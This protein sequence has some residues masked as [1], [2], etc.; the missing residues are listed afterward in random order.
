[1]SFAFAQRMSAGLRATLMVTFGALWLSGGGWL[2]LH[3]FFS[4][5]SDFGPAQNAWAPTVLRIH[6]WI[7]VAAVFLLGWITARH[8][9]DRWPHMIKRVSGLAVAGAAAILA[10]TGYAL[11]YTTDRV[12]EAA[13]V[14]HEA[15]GAAAV[16]FALIHWRRYRPA[17]RGVHPRF[18]A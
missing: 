15:L 8:V 13:G 3:Y 6:G 7:A 18:T 2:I 16:F 9:G 10:V 4:Q 11:Y 17:R 12:H 5:P 1:M 14:T